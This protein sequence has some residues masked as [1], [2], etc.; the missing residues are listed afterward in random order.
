MQPT[1]RQMPGDT[2]D[3]EGAIGQSEYVEQFAVPAEQLRYQKFQDWLSQLRELRHKASEYRAR[4]R[5]AT[6]DD[7]LQSLSRQQSVL[8][9]QTKSRMDA[10]ATRKQGN[11][12]Q[13]KGQ[14]AKHR[15]HDAH[16]SAIDST[17]TQVST[18]AQQQ[19]EPESAAAIVDHFPRPAD[20]FDRYHPGDYEPIDS[21]PSPLE[22]LPLRYG[23]AE[24]MPV[25]HTHDL[26]ASTL[27]HAKARRP[28]ARG[29]T[30]H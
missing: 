18:Y 14:P 8:L 17:P 10:A 13:Q 27:E 16:T 15:H 21:P 5:R 2:T 12:S 28:H 7:R 20:H 11:P 29:H 26:A 6:M 1:S 30:S 19:P 23:D 4:D 9:S 22:Q 25:S 24:V 3:G